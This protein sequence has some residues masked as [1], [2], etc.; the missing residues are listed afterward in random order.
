MGPPQF[1]Y[2]I[3]EPSFKKAQS[4]F[5]FIR[6]SIVL[7]TL[8]LCCISSAKADWPQAIAAYKKGDYVTAQKHWHKLASKG[9]TTAQTNLGLMHRG[10]IGVSKNFDKALVWFKK[11]A[12]RGTIKARLQIGDMYANGVYAATI[13]VRTQRQ[14]R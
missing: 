9:D 13:K 8:V 2:F 12:V 1:S 10:G 5:G 11:A 14:S 3:F 6:R 7:S 4:K